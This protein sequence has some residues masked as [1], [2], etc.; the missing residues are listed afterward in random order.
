M[1]DRV[2][3]TLVLK[4]LIV[5]CLNLEGVRPD[6]IGDDDPL[7]EG[8]FGLDS[9]DALE[10]VVAIEKKFGIKVKSEDVDPAAFATV[11]N[12]VRFVEGL[13]GTRPEISR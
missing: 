12:L 10:L 7:F 9:V 1:T 6:S 2:P 11:S 4:E 5:E 13:V 3:S 8:G